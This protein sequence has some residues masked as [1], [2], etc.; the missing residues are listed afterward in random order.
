MLSFSTSK[1]M[2]LRSATSEQLADKDG[3][4]HSAYI[5][6]YESY[7]RDKDLG[8]IITG[9]MS[10]SKESRPEPYCIFLT[11][12]DAPQAKLRMRNMKAMVDAVH[13]INPNVKVLP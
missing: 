9:H 10:I 3:I 7:A 5:R 12:E 2:F 8:I 11:P 6:L 1:G 13:M 4:P